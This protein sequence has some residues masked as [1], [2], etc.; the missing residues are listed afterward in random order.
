MKY[1]KISEEIDAIQWNADN[2]EEIKKF[3]RH[4]ELRHAGDILVVNHPDCSPVVFKG[5]W[6]VKYGDHKWDIMD[7]SDFNKNYEE[8]KE[9]NNE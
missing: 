1:R 6:I 4:L 9:E 3:C 7:S 5:N 2:L 8:I